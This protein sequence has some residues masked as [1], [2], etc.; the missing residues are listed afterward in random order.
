MSKFEELYNKL[1]DAW[2]GQRIKDQENYP[3]HAH[4]FD[5]HFGVGSFA[6]H[7]MGPLGGYEVRD[8]SEANVGSTYVI[9]EMCEIQTLVDRGV[10]PGVEVTVTNRLDDMLMIK[11]PG[12]GYVALRGETAKCVKVNKV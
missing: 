1:V 3:E 10:L 6:S 8:L 11:I 7:L 5:Q 9:T 4:T 2:V 12:S